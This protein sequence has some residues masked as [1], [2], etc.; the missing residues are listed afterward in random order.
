MLIARQWRLW[1]RHD[2]AILKRRQGHQ[3][4]SA[5]LWLTM[6]AAVLSSYRMF[7]MRRLIMRLQ[8]SISQFKGT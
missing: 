4:V 3:V 7:Y 5:I 8:P 6:R 2:S 1:L